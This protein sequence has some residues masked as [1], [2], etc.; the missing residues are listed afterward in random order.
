[1]ASDLLG[2]YLRARRGLLRPA[3]VGLVEQ[4]QRRVSGLRREEVALLAGI[5]ADYYLRLEQGRG[6]H[7]SDQV[8]RSLAQA[9][10]LDASATDYLLRLATPQQMAEGAERVPD[11][12]HNLLGL[13][14]WPG[15][16]TGR[17]FDVLA[18][19]DAAEKLS[20]Q[21][22]PGRNRLRSLF[23]DEAERELYADWRATAQ[24]FVAVVR[25]VVGERATYPAF[26]ALVDELTSRSAEFEEMW[27]R[28][29]VVARDSELA[30]MHH[31]VVGELQL[32]LERLDLAGVAGQ[33]L[34]VYHPERGTPDAARL[35][36][37]LHDR[38]PAR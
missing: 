7:P 29:D 38:A 28:H 19:N 2:D 25:D 5:S 6:G 23:L 4:G 33:S 20:P 9:L 36:S 31:P 37:L 12:I 26:Q 17:N 16:V 22:R 13:L 18:A 8:L 14:A 24:R 11:S 35:A 1:M 34:V 21:L 10:H 27:A 3:E 30:L 32:H 15:Y